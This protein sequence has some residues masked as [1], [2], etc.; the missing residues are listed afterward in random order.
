VAASSALAVLLVAAVGILRPEPGNRPPTLDVPS[1]VRALVGDPLRLALDATDPD[2]DE[3]AWS[4]AGMPPGA[5]LAPTGTFHWAPGPADVGSHRLVVAATD[6]E[7]ATRRAAIRVLVRH[8]PNPGLLAALGDSVASGHGLDW[9]HWLGRD[10][11][12]RDRSASYPALVVGARPELGELALLACSGHRARDLLERDVTRVAPL[13][14]DGRSRS[15]VEWAVLANPGVISLTVGANDLDFAR[16]ADA[17]SADGELD[18]AYVDARLDRVEAHLVPILRRLVEATDARI[19]VTTYHDPTAPRP[20]GIPGCRD[21]CFAAAAAEAVG[22]LND[23]IRAVAARSPR[24]RVAVA[25]V[26]DAFDGRGAPNGRG[27]DVLRG[28]RAPSWLPGAL[29]WSSGIHPY[30]ARGHD[31]GHEPLVSAAD[32]VHPNRAGARAYADAVL[33]ALTSLG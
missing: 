14:D 31:A 8:P 3:V 7:G 13:P 21:E 15:Q 19:V 26:S 4:A 2:G 27:P 25:D 30:C 12:W 33:D 20:H 10:P 16:P 1:E 22:R 11:C 5:R 28:L 6:P 18:D 9:R 32:C 29:T 17:L 24:D 23:R